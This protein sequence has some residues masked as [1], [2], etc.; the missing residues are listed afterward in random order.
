MHCVSEP[1]PCFWCQVSPDSWQLERLSSKRSTAGS[2]HT[3][4]PTEV[5]AT[6]HSARSV[7]SRA[8]SEQPP[9]TSGISKR[10]DANAALLGGIYTPLR[11]QQ[12]QQQSVLWSDQEAEERE[13]QQQQPMADNMISSPQAHSGTSAAGSSLARKNH[14]KMSAAE[15]RALEEREE[16]SRMEIKVND[17]Q[18][19]FNALSFKAEE[20]QQQLERLAEQEA[21]LR[22]QP[23]LAV[24]SGS[25]RSKK[26]PTTSRGSPSGG[27]RSGSP[28]PPGGGASAAGASTSGSA[29]G[30]AALAAGA[31]SSLTMSQLLGSSHPTVALEHRRM[32]VEGRLLGIEPLMNEAEEYSE[33][34]N[35]MLFRLRN[36]Q[37]LLLADIA[38]R[39]DRGLELDREADELQ[40]LAGE[41]RG[42][43]GVARQALEKAGKALERNTGT[44]SSKLAERRR[45]LELQGKRAMKV[46]RMQAAAGQKRPPG[47]APRVSK[48]SD[49]ELPAE[50]QQRLQRVLVATRMSSLVL[51]AQRDDN[52]EQVSRYEAAFKKMARAAGSN[53]AEV[54]IA[55]FIAR[56]ETRAGLLDERG[57]V[58]K[59]RADLDTDQQRLG[60]KLQEMQYSM[61]HPAH[62]ESALRRLD[63]KLTKAAGR[64]E[65]LTQQCSRLKDLQLATG[66]GCA[67]LLTRVAGAVPVL[68]PAPDDDFSTDVQN[69]EPGRRSSSAAA[70]GGEG[71][72]TKVVTAG[73]AAGS[74]LGDPTVDVAFEEKLVGMFKTCEHRLEKLVAF[75]QGHGGKLGAEGDER[76]LGERM[77]A[78]GTT[79]GPTPP[80]LRRRNSLTDEQMRSNQTPPL[81]RRNSL[82][83]DQMAMAMAASTSNT[84][85]ILNRRNSSARPIS[86]SSSLRGSALSEDAT[87]AILDQQGGGA[88]NIRVTPDGVAPPPEAAPPLGGSTRGGSILARDAR[89]S[90]RVPP[91]AFQAGQAAAAGGRGSLDDV[92]DADEEA[93][94]VG[95]FGEER[96]R[97]KVGERPASARKAN[98]RP[99]MPPASTGSAIGGRAESAGGPRGRKVKAGAASKRPMTSR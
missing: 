53:D 10:R 56:N 19:F 55:K 13:N 38:T 39:R 66:T 88:F 21:L 45:E 18:G 78:D 87:Q 44:Y 14:K 1:R 22:L 26:S 89:S 23:E 62:T 91:T 86:A 49:E 4:A 48:R 93:E 3:V 8:D 9:S 84:P 24:T 75:V 70:T 61:V 80:V 59:R 65:L 85:P 83:E 69:K 63:P 16:L 43:A 32:S 97:V 81:G 73:P 74:S 46:E 42:A 40:L 71:A 7:L 12:Q 60:S 54:V 99:P 98:E 6:P 20:K 41:A 57:Q 79:T 52:V 25:P 37:A 29:I 33:T 47:G 77:A 2:K 35:M 58:M 15:Q 28:I 31:S 30:G 96:R 72:E 36:Q 11:Q 67:A 64:L 76:T 34:L 17:L 5:M 27:S 94:R 95:Y 51:L 92:D 82:T 90:G 50:Q 68:G